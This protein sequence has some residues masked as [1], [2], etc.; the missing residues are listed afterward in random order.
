MACAFAVAAALIPTAG[1]SVADAA[2]YV[3]PPLVPPAHAHVHT[4][5][6]T[7]EF[8]ACYDWVFGRQAVNTQGASVTSLV[9]DPQV[10]PN[11]PN[12]HSLQ[13]LSIQNSTQTSTVEV[14]WI[15]SKGL[16]GDSLPHLFIFHWINGNP[17]CYNGCGY[18]QTSTT[19]KPGDALTAGSTINFGMQLI[20]GNWEVLINGSEI[21]YFPGSEWSGT[22][23]QGQLITAFGEVALDSNDAP[24]CTQM[25]NGQFGTSSTSS[26]LGNYQLQGGSAAPS[27]GVTAT[28][29]ANY[30]QGSV[31]ATGYHLGGPGSNTACNP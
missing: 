19:L 7:C 13:E 31:T 24:S 12:E 8:G 4:N 11:H 25:G 6:S 5:T 9:A 2:S 15:V 27:L 22:F 26:W 16:N 30:D 21:G 23:T 18:V 20:N 14:G 1:S 28:S 29:P 10:N 3:A 17:T